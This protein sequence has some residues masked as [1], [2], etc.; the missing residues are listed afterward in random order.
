MKTAHNR[1]YFLVY[2]LFVL[3]L[4]CFVC[5]LY[6]KWKTLRKRSHK[7]MHSII[8]VG[9]TH[10]MFNNLNI[11]STFCITHIVLLLSLSPSCS[12]TESFSTLWICC[13]FLF[14]FLFRSFSHLFSNSL[15]LF[16]FLKRSTIHSDFVWLNFLK[17]KFD[18][19]RKP[20]KI[21]LK[22]T[23]L[24]KLFSFCFFFNFF[25]IF[26]SFESLARISEEINH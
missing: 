15:I 18:C 19:D 16:H 3:I 2:F 21:G 17:R 8:F 5:F 23:F 11:L 10:I 24:I 22:F 4:F 13:F 14:L 25:V 12:L 20:L 7:K 9:Y 26:S 6:S 1:F